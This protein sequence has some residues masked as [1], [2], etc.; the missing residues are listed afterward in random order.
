LEE[1]HIH[2]AEAEHMTPEAHIRKKADLESIRNTLREMMPEFHRCY[3]IQTLEIF[4]SYVR[5]EERK[6]SDLDLLIEFIPG[7][8][9]SLFEF[10][11]LEQTFSDLLGVKVDLV[12]KSSIKP[13]LRQKILQEAQPV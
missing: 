3:G 2:Q 11:A 5:G 10:V 9:I 1:I 12:E 4:G 8:S 13:A 7:R 6:K